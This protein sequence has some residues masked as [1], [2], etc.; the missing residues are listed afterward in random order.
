VI[1][2]YHPEQYPLARA[3]CARFEEAELWYIRPDQSGF[4]VKGLSGDLVDLDRLAAERAGEA[5][6]GVQGPELSQVEERL[7]MRLCE[8][9][10][11][12]SRPFVPG[13]RVHG[14]RGHWP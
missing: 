1:V 4:A 14:P 7:L 13:A 9:E 8:L 10:V 5:R 6:L 12:S 3:L 2:L 11:I